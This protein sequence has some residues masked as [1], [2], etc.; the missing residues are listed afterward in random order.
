MAQLP[1]KRQ[2][3]L[4]NFISKYIG[5]HG[6]SPTYE[7]MGDALDVNSPATIF[8][9][10]KQLARKQYI[11]IYEGAVR[12]IEIIDQNLK[13]QISNLNV[14]L[15]MIG[16]IAA[17]QP[18]EVITQTETII[19]SSTLI[20]GK[21]SAFVLRVKGESMIDEGILDGDYVVIEEQNTANNGDIVV[22]LLPNGFATLKKFYRE[23]NRIRLEPANSK[24]DPIYAT[25]VK[26]QGRVKGVIRK[27]S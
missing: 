5:K 18:I 21:K 26:I 3:Q 13:S 17:G 14:E 4:L 10:L 19:V 22:A 6:Y 7:E 23:K 16:Y 12:G 27:F 2:K 20:S 11:K 15:P 9:H 24:M 8:D 1:T 25:S